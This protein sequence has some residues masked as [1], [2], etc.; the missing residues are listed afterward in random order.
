[1]KQ[2]KNKEKGFVLMTSLIILAISTAIGGSVIYTTSKQVSQSKKS[3][4]SQQAFHAA[5][6][7][8]LAAQKWLQTQYDGG[9]AIKE[10]ST[11]TIQCFKGF[12]N[13]KKNPKVVESDNGSG[14]KRRYI[15]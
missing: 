6:A 2:K 1:M 7:G 5:E 9:K 15:C 11:D 12:E 10:G 8:M 3:E 13:F 4:N 14:K